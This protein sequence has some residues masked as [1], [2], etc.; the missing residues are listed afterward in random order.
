MTT[1]YSGP[2]RKGSPRFPDPPP[3][4]PHVPPSRAC[5]FRVVY[6][7]R[8]LRKLEEKP[9]LCG[10]RAGVVGLDDRAPSNAARKSAMMFLDKVTEG[11][12]YEAG[13]FTKPRI[14]PR[15]R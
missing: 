9:R 2:L 5:R 14:S 8:G 7:N 11:F 15:H 4:I 13:Y 10:L 6:W 1:N 3:G 12:G